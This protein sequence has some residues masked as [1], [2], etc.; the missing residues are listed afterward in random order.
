MK[1]VGGVSDEE[2][3]KMTHLNAMR[4]FQYDPFS[5]FARE[6]CTVGALRANALDVDTAPRSMVT[7]S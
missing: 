4:L 3:D 6:D 1:I 2:I 7:R 5:H